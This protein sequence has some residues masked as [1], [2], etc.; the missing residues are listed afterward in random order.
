MNHCAGQT[1]RRVGGREKGV[2]EENLKLTLGAFAGFKYR[3]F[4]TLAGETPD[5]VMLATESNI[6]NSS[7]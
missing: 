7:L 5:K 3:M 1:R 6:G 4:E 2:R